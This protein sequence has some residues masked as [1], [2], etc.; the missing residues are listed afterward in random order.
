VSHKR[1]D[2]AKRFDQFCGR[3][4]DGLIAVTIVLAALV[5]LAAAYRTAEILVMPSGFETIG[6]T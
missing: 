5:F 3:L 6:T 1:R 4:N 2:L